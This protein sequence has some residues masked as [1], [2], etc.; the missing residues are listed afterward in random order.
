MY[1]NVN[2]GIHTPRDL[3]GARIGL[4][5]Y[6][7]T[8]AVRA[9]GDLAHF[10]GVDG[11]T[12]TWV[13][14]GKEVVDVPLPADVKIETRA[15]MAEIEQEFA[16]GKIQALFVSRLPKPFRD[17]HLGVARFFENP[18]TEE[19][20]YFRTE[21]YFPIMHVLAFK[22]TLAEQYPEL[23]RALFDIF[24]QA[25]KRAAERW[26]DPNWSMLLW[27]RREYERQNV[28]SAVDPWKNGLEANRKNIERF[29]CY[30]HEQGLTRRLLTPEELFVAID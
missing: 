5:A 28:L 16:D 14:P 19:E 6:Q 7:N 4:S 24:E 27:G 11:S 3:T 18:Q 22:K 1:K 12:V 21:G 8:L 20:R 25:R 10:Y 29:A 23:P 15:S 13:T 17:G 2:C 26:V 30:S 9:K